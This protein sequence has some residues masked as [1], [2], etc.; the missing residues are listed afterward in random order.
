M[1]SIN[2]LRELTKEWRRKSITPGRNPAAD[3]VDC[4]A[5]AIEAEVAERYMELPLDADG[6]PIHCGDHIVSETGRKDDVFLIGVSA[7][8]TTR[9]D[10]CYDHTK[11][12][13]Y[14]P[15]TLEDVL[16]DF[17]SAY[18][19][20]GGEDEE[21]DKYLKIVARYASEIRELL[22]VE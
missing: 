2:E 3:K 7:V 9:R 19:R 16:D 1:E 6:V 5:D 21:H 20:I 8:M 18:D 13:H 22:G 11:V 14:K 12:R 17:A 15:R 4:I 10:V